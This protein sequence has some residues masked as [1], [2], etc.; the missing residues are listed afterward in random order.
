MREA[1][2]AMV[3]YGF[4]TLDLERIE[5]RYVPKNQASA[6]VLKHCHFVYEGCL[7]KAIYLNDHRLHDMV[8]CSILKEE[9]EVREK[10]RRLKRLDRDK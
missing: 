4:E 10:Q 3:Q 9:Y 6:A 8:I 5:A 7:R 2:K 1:V